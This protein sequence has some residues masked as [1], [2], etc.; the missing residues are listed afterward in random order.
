MGF[1]RKRRAT[2]R[3]ARWTVWNNGKRGLILYGLV[4]YKV[5]RRTCEIG[6]RMAL[7]AARSDVLRLVMGK[8]LALVG[9]GTAINAGGVNIV[10]Y[11]IVVPSMF[12]V[13]MLAAYMPAR[14][15]TRIAPTQA[16]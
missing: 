13:T 3:C 6:I 1:P 7:G 14:R 12:L 11:V 5:S 16:L 4:A 8:G 15:A 9:T 2:P 10:A